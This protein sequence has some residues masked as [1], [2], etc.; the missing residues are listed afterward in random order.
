M[1]TKKGRPRT[2]TRAKPTPE[3][4]SEEIAKQIKKFKKNG[5]KI[6][7]GPKLKIDQEREIARVYNSAQLQVH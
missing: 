2:K 5:G 1:A 6:T 3:I 7:K 4:S